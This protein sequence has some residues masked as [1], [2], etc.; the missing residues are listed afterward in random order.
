MLHELFNER[1]RVKGSSSPNKGGNKKRIRRGR[2][3][4]KLKGNPSPNDGV[5]F[6][7]DTAPRKP[8]Y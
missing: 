7:N 3:Y 1:I 6:A 4:V 5:A 2:S 8:E